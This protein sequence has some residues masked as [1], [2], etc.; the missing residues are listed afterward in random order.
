MVGSA[1]KYSIFSALPFECLEIGALM[2]HFFIIQ[3]KTSGMSANS[4]EE[5][6]GKI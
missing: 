6:K 5:L 4:S 2:T 3:Y 1:G